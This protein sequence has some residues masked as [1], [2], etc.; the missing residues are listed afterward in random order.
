MELDKL[1]SLVGKYVDIT[2][3]DGD[4]ASGWVVEITSA[5]DNEGRMI[6]FDYGMGF[7]VDKNAT[8]K[9]VEPP[10]GDT[11]LFNPDTPPPP[12]P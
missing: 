7:F 11:G 2:Y 4:G 10:E 5:P 8:I 9:E 3:E 12:F 6:Q 1:N